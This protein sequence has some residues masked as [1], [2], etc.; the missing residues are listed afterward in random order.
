VVG[1]VPPSELFPTINVIITPASQGLA[2]A[3]A[4]PCVL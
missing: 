2:N 1:G 3:L 4:N